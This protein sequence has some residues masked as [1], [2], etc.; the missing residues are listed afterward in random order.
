MWTPG[1]AR[2][3]HAGNMESPYTR[4]LLSEVLRYSMY[5][6]KGAAAKAME[7]GFGDGRNPASRELIEQVLF[8]RRFLPTY[9]AV[10]GIVV[11][12]FGA[13]HWWTKLPQRCT[14]QDYSKKHKLNISPASS[15]SSSTLQG[16]PVP[17]T[18]ASSSIEAIE[19]TRLLS[20]ESSVVQAHTSVFTRISCYITSTLLYQPSPIRAVTSPTNLL[21]QNS[22]T[23]LV[24]LFL[25]LNMFYLLY[26]TPL[27]I[28]MLFVFADRAGL[29]F[30]VNLPVLYI[31]A[32]KT[33][34]P[35]KLLTGW[36]YEGLNI[37]HR[38]LGEWMIA[39]SVVHSM[40]MFGVW[41]TLLRPLH[42]SLERFLSTKLV[43]LGMF[44]LISYIAIWVT[45]TGYF[46]RLWYETFLGLHIF[47]QVV[48]LLLLFLHH[49]GSRIYVLASVGIWAL[50][51]II[52]R[53]VLC[54]KKLVA[55]LQIAEDCETVLLFCDVDIR[56]GILGS[57]L[58][59]LN[60]WKSGQ[61]VF[62]TVPGI[63]WQHCL[64]SHP[65]TISSPAPP[66]KYKGVWPLQLT[67]RAQG[68]FSKQL[69][70]YARLHQHTEVILDGPYGSVD[71]LEALQNADR[72]CLIAGGSGV[73]VTYPLAW[74][75]LVQDDA[76][77]LVSTRI[78]YSNGQKHVPCLR[79]RCLPSALSDG[80]VMHLWINQHSNHEN[81]LTAIPREDALKSS[82]IYCEAE[83]DVGRIWADNTINVASLTTARYSTRDSQKG[84]SEGRPDVALELRCWVESGRRKGNEDRICV[85]VSGPDG[86]VRDVRNA[87]AKLLLEGWNI[88]V[89]V[90][91]FGW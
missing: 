69:L 87:A 78:V 41:Y 11:L 34:Q 89:F 82:P 20:P 4:E 25:S 10:L 37:F 64:Q 72:Q 23:L 60:G 8:T 30:A 26:H 1:H 24:L 15:S 71:I 5:A 51:R 91:K 27:S 38:R 65:F 56:P 73:A 29:L 53:M 76:S 9:L 80:Q 42:F 17:K 54:R 70:E 55:T 63:G 43:L 90:E 33:N 16:T 6:H 3:E 84:R 12:F 44:A 40:G 50:D 49:P 67:V 45:S 21:P 86:L 19:T 46:R 18:R 47:L 52:G 77:A 81:W 31:L 32:A 35:L 59:I 13:A 57:S 39:L 62:V 88:E 85:V 36:S 58:N 14:N 2:Y 66:L 61:H 79:N 22:T 48:A 74:S 68:G 75:L 28:P 83:T 7:G